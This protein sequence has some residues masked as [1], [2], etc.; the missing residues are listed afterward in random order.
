MIDNG[1]ILRAATEGALDADELTPTAL[2]FYGGDLANM[3][4]FVYVPQATGTSPTLDV[5]IEVSDDNSTFVDYLKFPQ[6]T[7]AGLY[8]LTGKTNKR[9]RR[10]A[11]DTGGTTPNFGNVVIGCMPAGRYDKW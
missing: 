6:I 3:V 4:Y 8:F 10:Y 2:D 11:A 7:A 5:E 9:Y 1:V